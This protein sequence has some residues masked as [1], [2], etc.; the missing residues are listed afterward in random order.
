MGG[1][2]VSLDAREDRGRENGVWDSRRRDVVGRDMLSYR[3]RL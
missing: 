3:C 2:S 1:M